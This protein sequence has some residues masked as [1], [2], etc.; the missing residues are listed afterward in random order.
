MKFETYPF[1]KLTQLL[2]DVTPNP[3]LA[4]MSLTIGEPQFETPAFIRQELCDAAALLNKYPKTAGESYLKEA[5]RS[6]LKQRFG[7]EIAD[8]QLIPTF[9]TRELL[10]NFPQFYLHDLAD[11]TMAF[12]N[13]FYQ[14]YEGA[15]IASGARILH[16]DLTPENGFQPP[17]DE[18]ALSGCDLVILNTPN[19]PTASVMPFEAMRRW[20]RLALEHDFFLLNDECYIDL[21]LKGPLP[22]MLEASLAEGNSEFRNVAVVNSVSKRSSAPGLRSGFI[23]GDREVLREYLR[24]RTYVGCASPLPLQRAAARAWADQ[25]HVEGFRAK[26]RRNFELAEKILGV[27]APEATFYIWMEVGDELAFTR[28]LYRRYNLKV[29][30][31]SFLGRNGVGRGYVRLA[32]V[33]EEEPMREALER[34]AA[35]I[36]E[37][38]ME[39]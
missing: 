4:P 18:E 12:P 37:W 3:D 13:P 35:F 39:N 31:G 8:D 28:E 26:Y 2:K 16:L 6:Y 27:E 32:L 30:P 38:R 36:R 24:Y 1:E 33:Y 7:L 9:G 17:I 34:V 23:A 15:A 22:S 5:M 21:W 19:N 14:I 29:L 25:Q 10:F 11:S 20:V